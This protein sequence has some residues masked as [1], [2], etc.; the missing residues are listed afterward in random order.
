LIGEKPAGGWS[1]SNPNDAGLI[2]D[3]VKAG[4]RRFYTAHDW[5]FLYPLARLTTSAPYSTGTI[6][7]SSGVVTLAGGGTFPSWAAD[8]ELIPSSGATYTVNTRDSDTQ[9]TLD[10]TTVTV[11]AGA[12]YTLTRPTYTLPDDYGGMHEKVLWF[13]PG[14]AELY[15]PVV[16]I[17]QY[18]ISVRRQQDDVTQRPEFAAERVKPNVAATGTRYELTFWPIPDAA[19]TM[20][21]RYVVNPDY[22]S[23]DAH[24]PYGGFQHAETLLGACLTESEAYL[25]S[26]N[27]QLQRYEKL[28][29]RSIKLDAR[30]HSAERLGVDFDRS[31]APSNIGNPLV[32][33]DSWHVTYNG[34]LPPT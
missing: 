26:G 32:A 34:V 13:R 15:P 5:S 11:A 10:D 14:S 17:S 7:V 25:E 29:A 18:D 31:D 21:Y 12:S 33:N 23:N 24:Y 3:V 16:L 22:L 20:F 30:A 9:V 28:L 2:V 8:G 6:T 19:Y 27:V 1:A 4:F